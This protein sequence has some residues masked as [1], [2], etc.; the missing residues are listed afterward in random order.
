M[1]YSPVFI[2]GT[3]RCGSTLLSSIINTHPDM[4]SI[5]EFFSFISDLGTNIGGAFPE[6]PVSA[7]YFWNLIGNC[8]KKQNLMIKQDV[9]MDEVVYPWKDPRYQHTDQTGVPAILQTTLPHLTDECDALFIKLRDFI[10][11]QKEQPIQAHYST[12]FHYLQT[13]FNAKFWVERSGGSLR[14]IHRLEQM[15]PNA[16]FIHIVRDGRDCAIS[17]SKH[18]GFRMVVTAFQMIEILGLDPY[19]D[20]DREFASDLPDELY[21]LL[22]EHFD[23]QA[24]ID[25]DI[26]L[27]LYGHYWSGELA[28]A[29]ETLK[30][31]PKNRLLTVQYEDLLQQPRKTMAGLLAFMNLDDT[32]EAWLSHVSTMIRK[33]NSSWRNLPTEAQKRLEEACRPGFE[34]LE[35]I[36]A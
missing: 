32:D 7:E 15:F 6:N 19:E 34:V 22:P 18:Y 35:G 17:M 28:A 10:L 4:V 14:I 26:P 20:N 30:N 2:V 29:A 36:G 12:L 8:H 11:V 13:T 27:S 1:D 5:S 25:Y 16:K 23:R 24:F 3:G 31:L 9:A 21:P 33:P